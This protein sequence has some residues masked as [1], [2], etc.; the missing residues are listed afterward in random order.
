MYVS[1]RKYNISNFR[2]GVLYMWSI[3]Q[4]MSAFI[5]AASL[6][7]IVTVFTGM[8]LQA[9]SKNIVLKKIQ[10]SRQWIHFA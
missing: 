2:I 3:A 9:A 8:Q 10:H 5:Q 1:V 6:E 7:R 4:R